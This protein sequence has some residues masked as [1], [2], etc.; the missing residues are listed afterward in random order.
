MALAPGTRLGPHEILAPLGQGGMGEVYRARDT[1]LGREL[2]IKILPAALAADPLRLALLKHE[3][4]SASALNH[5]NIV[6]IYEIGQA[7]ST[8]YIAMELVEGASLRELILAGQLPLR[9]LLSIAA[10]IGDGLAKAHGAGIVHRDLKPENLMVSNDGFVKIL[11]FGLAK[12]I[13]VRSETTSELSTSS[14][15]EIDATGIAGTVGYM[16]PEQASAKPLD[17]RSDQFSLGAVLYELATGARAFRRETPVQTLAAI[18]EDDPLPIASLN[19]RLP[20]PFCWIVERCLS[21]NPDERYASTRDLARDLASIREHLLEAP[22][23]VRGARPTNLPVPRTRFV[24]RE[25]ERAALGA[26]LERPDVRIVSLTG[27]GGIG[28]TRL[29]LQV[30]EEVSAGFPAGVSFV[31]LDSARDSDQMVAAISRT[32]GVRETPGQ[33]LFDSLKEHVAAPRRGPTLL[34]LDNFE[35]LAS[36]APA[37]A[38]LVAAAPEMKVVVTSRSPLHVY[39]EHEFPVPPLALPDLDELPS[40]ERLTQYESVA[41]F[42]QRA[43][44]VKPDFTLTK[45]N[46]PAIAE[47]VARLDGLPLALELAAARVKLLSPAAMQS[48]LEKR[49]QLLTGGAMDLPARQRTL[50]GAIEWSYDLLNG[51]EQKLFRRLSVFADGCTLEAV[52][53]IC[54]AKEDLALDLLDGMA[55]MVDKSLVR[56]IE[57]E[58]EEPRFVMLETIREYAAERLASSGDEEITRRTHA[59]Y[60]LVL[61]EE[62]GSARETSV[63]DSAEWLDRC[64]RENENLRAALD[65]L[66][67]KDEGQWGLRLGGA[68]FQFWER[69]EYISEGREWL[70]RLLALPSSAARDRVRAR[71]VFGAG[72]LAGVQRDYEVA[73]AFLTESLEINR[74]TGDKWAAAVSLN[75]LAVTALA[76]RNVAA[77]RSLSEQNL[78][79]WRELG[80]KA[81]VARSLSN[82][83]SVVK[84]QGD[85]ALARTLYDEALATFREIGDATAAARVLNKKGDVARDQGDIAEARNLYERSLETFREFG[86]RWGTA[87]A[88]ADLGNLA[89]ERRDFSSARSLYR[90]SL[91]I[92]HELD[93]KRGVAQ[94]L[95]NFAC[96]AAAQGEAKRALT[97]AG[98]AAAL[99]HELGTPLYPSEQ[100]KLEA[101]LES[102]RRRLPGPEGASAWMEGW[103]TPLAKT[104][105]TALSADA[106]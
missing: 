65:W 33:S 76:Q 22:G 71:A 80:D 13:P 74:E 23:E 102:A 7:D 6:T 64:D 16:S 75:A 47:I 104:V 1:R 14:H 57:T 88:L 67:R 77:A 70:A 62:I 61:A 12:L 30:A 26:L 78:E 82:L 72:V 58:G 8:F 90:D 3:A 49:L 25:S 96:T 48:R 95:E 24:G 91:R 2:A 38:D 98:S 21:K 28:K 92:F 66:C 19:A 86:D 97:L 55:S 11:D 87:L 32:L 93:Y 52:E 99:R 35:Q 4:R 37:V 41:L 59:A 43:Q 36:A 44:A 17:F 27:F 54:N 31:P 9:R 84:E 39:G 94:V 20:A 29:A 106:G 5:P 81:A 15:E 40:P 83:A 73:N 53:A 46:A 42:L 60:C 63:I 101:N 100:A 79:V 45:E 56:Q 89:R 10:Q 18:L 68:L 105:D 34:V 50:R 85:Y 51:D 69:R 103:T